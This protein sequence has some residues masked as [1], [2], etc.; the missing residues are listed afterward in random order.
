[1]IG[2]ATVLA[3]VGML[4]VWANRLLF[5]PENWSRTSTQLLSNPA[6]RSATANYL[7][8]Q[9]YAN[10]DVSALIRSG[11]PPQLQGLASPAAGALRNLA[12]QGTEE[13]L[14]RPRVQSLWAKANRA[15]DQV[16]IDVVNG[17]RGPVGIKQGVV[18]LDLGAI[19]DSTAA[20]LGLPANLGAKLPP[21]IAQ[22]TVLRSDQLSAVQDAGNAVRHLALWLTILVPILYGV[23]IF[24]AR[25]R[26]RRTLMTVGTTIVLA[27]L[28]GIAGR[29]VL[30]NR[31]VDSLVSDASLRPAAQ[32]TVAI[33]T[34]ML[35]T[36]AGAFILV[37]AV[38]VAAAW[39]A[40]P[41]RVAVSCRRALAPFLRDH[42]AA[43]FAIAAAAMLLVFIWNPIPATGTPVGIIVFLTLALLGTETLRRQTRA[44]FPD[45]RSGATA[46]ALR[47]RLHA[48][49]SRRAGPHPRTSSA[50]GSSDQPVVDQLERLAA[51]RD[52]RSIT[53]EEYETAKRHLLDAT[54]PGTGFGPTG[55]GTGV[56]PTGPGTGVGPTGPGTG[57]N[58]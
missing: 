16:F 26:R 32:A 34:E 5:N 58:R 57:A 40:G 37:G 29:S 2:L 21:S 28:V 4:S 1:M 54:G 50:D 15:A 6:I 31:I 17:G 12:V 48:A 19:V 3:V 13:A 49:R 43:T 30:E 45:A 33:S 38:L 55:P 35:A 51:L 27:G 36:I 7:V 22:L 44:E 8:D 23:A 18:T 14:K 41:N 46:A 47:A 24:L 52:A 39:F 25:G 53:G 9:L 56:V 42:P 20:R 10:V 11:L